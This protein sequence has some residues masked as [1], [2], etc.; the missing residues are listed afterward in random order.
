MKRR[1]AAVILSIVALFAA[2]GACLLMNLNSAGPLQPAKVG[3]FYYVWYDPELSTSWEYPK[4][5][6]RPVLGHY[7]SCDPEIIEQQL[8]WMSDLGIDFVVISWR[9]FDSDVGYGRFT[10]ESAK[11]VF[12]TAL[13]KNFTSLKFALMVEPENLN[14]SFGEIYG[15]VY[16]EFVLPYA[17]IYYNISKP[18]LC[19]FDNGSIFDGTVPSDIRFETILVGQQNNTEWV[20]TD[21]NCYVQPKRMPY[22]DQISVSPR[23]DDSRLNRTPSCTVDANLTEGVF[24]AEWE[25][26]TQLWKRGEINIVIITSWNEYPE[27]TAIEPHYDATAVR[28]NQ[29]PYY[30]YNITKEYIS[31][32]HLLSK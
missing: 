14:H 8:C 11:Q 7:N 24:Y 17:S 31:Q 12:K 29:N 16:E 13:T 30:L 21:L 18:L 27:R 32:L 2:F 9:G 15:H 3:V 22:S 1:L 19:F 28:Q 10:E 26:A 6:D 5:V 4:I 23:Y 25:N 20:Y